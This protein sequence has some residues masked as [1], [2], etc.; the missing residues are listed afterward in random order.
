MTNPP[1]CDWIISRGWFAAVAIILWATRLLPE[2]LTSLLFFST[3]II[4]HAAPV[5]VVFSGFQSEAFWLLLSGFVL[6]AAISKVGMADRIALSL[7]PLLSRSW[8]SMV[9]GVVAITYAL[10]FVMPSNTGRSTLLMPIIFALA[11]RTG[12]GEGSRGR[13]ALALAVG[14]GTY[15]LSASIL[16]AS[17]PNLIMTS[18]AVHAYGVKFDYLTYLLLH[19]PTLGILKG[20]IIV[21][22]LARAFPASPLKL[23]ADATANK[24]NATERR[25]AAL[26]L[27]TLCLWITDSIHG[28]PPAWIGLTS[29]CI[30]LLPRIGFLSGED[31]VLDMNVRTC[32]YLAGILALASVVTWSRLGEEIGNAIIPWLPLDPAS[33]AKSFA[34]MLGLA[35]LLNFVATANELPAVFTPLAKG[36]ADY[37]GIP[38]G[39]VLMS[40]VLVYAAPVLPYQAIPIVVAIRVG[41][42]PMRHAVLACAVIGA[43]SYA[44]LAPLDYFWFRALGWIP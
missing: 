40:Q 13:I 9:S 41:K 44:F 29:A 43:I 16:P 38:L 10:G 19:A 32:I 18:A 20:V 27:A 22:F 7:S 39:A 2:Y 12:L 1:H 5:N 3:V 17:L 24:L 4:F 23:P 21:T 33:P 6:G 14:L 28:V 25:L 30:C 34:S 37:S 26:L 36:L 31:F 15:E 11:D 42:V 8:F 35:G